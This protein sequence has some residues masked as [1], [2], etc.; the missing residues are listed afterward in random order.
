MDMRKAHLHSSHKKR[1]RVLFKSFEERM[2]KRG[3]LTKTETA[4][5][6]CMLKE[7]N[8]YMTKI[9]KKVGTTLAY[10]SYLLRYYEKEGLIERVES[11]D[12]KKKLFKLTEKG[13]KIAKL[14]NEVYSLF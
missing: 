8:F 12:R 7:E 9:M 2:Q 10:T 5:L 1:E 3:F 11:K 14:L 13:E 4:F 6:L